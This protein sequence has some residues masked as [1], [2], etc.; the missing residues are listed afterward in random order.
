VTPSRQ[1]GFSLIEVLVAF[2]ILAL[3]VSVIF[4]LFA[5]GLRNTAVAGE[6]GVALALAESKMAVLQGMDAA[7]LEPQLQEGSFDG[8]YHWRSEVRPAA[9]D[10]GVAGVAVYVLAVRVSWGGTARNRNVDLSTLR[11]GRLP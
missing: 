8:A 11:L 3:A 2:A 9:G 5:T 7:R 4:S 1:R 6:Y 10:S